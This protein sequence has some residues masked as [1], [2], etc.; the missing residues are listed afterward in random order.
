[1]KKLFWFF[2][3][4][5]LCSDCAKDEV[6]VFGSISGVVKDV[7]TRQPLEGVS[8]SLEPGGIVK[9]T[10]KDGSYSFACL[11]PAFSLPVAGIH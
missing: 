6:N 8:V 11:A 7:Q 9:V 1:M 5:F 3:L 10:G 4:A 2:V